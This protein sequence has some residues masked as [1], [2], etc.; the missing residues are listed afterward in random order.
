MALE[1]DDGRLMEEAEWARQVRRGDQD[2]LVR[3]Y[4]AYFDRVY[5]YFYDM[6]DSI[7]EAEV[8]TAETFHLAVNALMSDYSL[9]QGE[10]FGFWLYGLA[11]RIFEEH[12]HASLTD[13]LKL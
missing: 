5:H 4:E 3:L 9:W 13:D 11:D 8:L 6:V 12:S 2:A 10:G 1:A 7:S